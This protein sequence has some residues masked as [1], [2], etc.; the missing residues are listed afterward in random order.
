V[1]NVAAVSPSS[2]GFV[3]AFPCDRERPTASNVNFVGSDVVANLVVVRPDA[4]GNVCLFSLAATDLVVDLA[5]GFGQGSGYDSADTPLRLVDTRIGLGVVQRRLGPRETLELVVPGGADADAVVLNV[6]A[7]YPSAPGFITVYPCDRDRPVASNLN[8]DRLDVV[9]NL[10]IVRPDADGTVCLFT[11]TETDLVV[12][13]AGTIAADTGYVPVDNPS[14]ILDTRDG[15]G[16][17]Q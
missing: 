6:T 14:R 13:L 4:D 8:F 5:G 3:T 16:I 2:P 10:V 1:L 15:T 11:L 9:A 7:V 12:D 17:R